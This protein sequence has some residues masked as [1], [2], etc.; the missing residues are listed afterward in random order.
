M[1][2]PTLLTLEKMNTDHLEFLAARLDRLAHPKCIDAAKVVR[3]ALRNPERFQRA[4][5]EQALC[6]DV[7]GKLEHARDD[8]DDI[9]VGLEI[10]ALR[11]EMAGHVYTARLALGWVIRAPSAPALAPSLEDLGL[12]AD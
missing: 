5:A 3:R 2:D 1:R 9:G 7:W 6:H 12:M 10:D 11:A 8:V 4:D